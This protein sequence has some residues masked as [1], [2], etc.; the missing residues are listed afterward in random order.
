MTAGLMAKAALFL[1]IGVVAAARRQLLAHAHRHR[2]HEV[3]TTGLHVGVA[4]A[5]FRL[6]GGGKLRAISRGVVLVVQG[7]CG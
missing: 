7:G 4:F 3:G 1:G 6:D 5:G 2:V